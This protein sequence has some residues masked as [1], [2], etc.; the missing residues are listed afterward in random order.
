MTITMQRQNEINAPDCYKKEG[1]DKF[2]KIKEKVKKK[3]LKFFYFIII[4]LL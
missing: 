3:S 2:T 4:F 1:K